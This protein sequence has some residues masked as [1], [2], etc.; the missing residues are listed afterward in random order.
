MNHTT[1][2]NVQ[3]IRL[4]FKSQKLTFLKQR[5]QSGFDEQIQ[6]VFQFSGEVLIFQRIR[7]K[8]IDCHSLV[9]W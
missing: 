1:D 4:Y 8:R 6:Q 9:Q 2:E 7:Q 5:L 3:N